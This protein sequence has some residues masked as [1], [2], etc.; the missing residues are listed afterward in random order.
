L[1]KP[2]RLSYK[3]LPRLSGSYDVKGTHFGVGT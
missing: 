2:C 3:Q 1:A